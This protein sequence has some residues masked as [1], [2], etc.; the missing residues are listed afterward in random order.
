VF[1]EAHAVDLKEHTSYSTIMKKG[2]SNRR[3]MS[4]CLSWRHAVP[5]W[6]QY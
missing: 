4:N 1:I 5:A 3:E 6:P 2:V